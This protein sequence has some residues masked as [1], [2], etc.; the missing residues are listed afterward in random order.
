M[1]RT[2]SESAINMVTRPALSRSRDTRQSQVFSF[3]PCPLDKSLN[4]TSIFSV[5]PHRRQTG[6]SVG[7]CYPN[8]HD[9][10]IVYFPAWQPHLNAATPMSQRSPPRRAFQVLFRNV[11]IISSDVEFKGSKLVSV[12]CIQA[13]KQYQ[14]YPTAQDR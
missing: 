11:K 10:P 3:N 6:S 5:T 1:P 4:Y 9:F 2:E 13:I 12:S 8:G 7:A 14:T